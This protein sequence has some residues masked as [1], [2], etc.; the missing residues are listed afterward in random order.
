M[1]NNRLLERCEP[2]CAGQRVTVMISQSTAITD[3][4]VTRAVSTIAELL[5]CI[6]FALY[7][8]ADLQAFSA[9]L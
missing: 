7:V 3:L 8:C 9:R 1:R 4:V 6:A 5:V 2:I